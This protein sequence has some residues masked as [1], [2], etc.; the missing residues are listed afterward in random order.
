VTVVTVMRQP[1]V[2]ATVTDDPVGVV[3]KHHVGRWITAAVLLALV[4]LLLRSVVSNDRFGWPA[5]GD[6]LF[7]ARVVHGVYLT[8]VLTVACMAIGIALGIILAVMRLSPNRVAQAVA[9]AYGSFFRGIPVLVQLIFWFNISALYPHLTFGLPGV[10][11]N[12]NKLVTPFVAGIL[13]LGLH[14]AAYMAEIVR[15]GIRAVDE[16]QVEA[17]RALGLRRSQI[18][19]RIVLPQA[20]AMIVPPTGN[21]VVGMLKTSSLVSVLAVAEL[22]YSAQL[23]YSVNYQTIPLLV[24][25]SLWYLALTAVF[26]AGQFWVE[27]HY[28]R[29]RPGAPA[30]GSQVPQFL[31]R[32]SSRHVT[33]GGTA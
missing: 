30:S 17:A 13:G 15:G 26:S 6:Y 31:R 21:E 24:V 22:L 10:D 14:E 19:R 27:R 16:G 4:A 25:A 11:L 29:G 12:A 8:L 33:E 7:D 2:P 1:R 3:K 18:L 23:I 28:S 5:V 20:M 32:N 9:L